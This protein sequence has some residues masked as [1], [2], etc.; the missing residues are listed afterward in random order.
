MNPDLMT[1]SGM[2]DLADL[3]QTMR[4]G[5]VEYL[6][7]HD[8]DGGMVSIWRLRNTDHFAVL[9]EY[10]GHRVGL[11]GGITG[12]IDDLLRQGVRAPVGVIR[13]VADE[14]MLRVPCWFQEGGAA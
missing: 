7:C 4:D 12:L 8:C 14:A 2:I 9:L 1:T 13:S 10:M 3:L 6:G 5:R 11:C